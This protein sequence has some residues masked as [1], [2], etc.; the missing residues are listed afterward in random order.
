MKTWSRLPL[1][2][3]VVSIAVVWLGYAFLVL[4]LDS[5]DSNSRSGKLIWTACRL[6]AA[7]T[8]GVELGLRPKFG[9]LEQL[10]AYNR[11]LRTG[12]LPPGVDPN[13][14][15]RWLRR[16]GW[17]TFL[18]WWANIFVWFGLA[19]SMTSQSAYRWLPAAAFLLLAIWGFAGLW[20]AAIRDAV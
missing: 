10:T 9:S 13:V 7:V 20:G 18:L 1:A 5:L 11:A 15:R 19:S 4:D 12:E 17:T 16:S 14:W 2:V 3:R 8:V 6:G